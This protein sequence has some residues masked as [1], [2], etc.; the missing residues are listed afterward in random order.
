MNFIFT[1][2]LKRLAIAL[3]S[4]GV[5]AIVYGFITDSHKAWVSLLHSNFYF[6]AI[7]LAS[8]FFLSVQYVAEVGWSV[9]IKRI[10][11][12]IGMYLPW[13]CAFML[14]IFAIGNHSIYDW[15]HHYF[16]E[17]FIEGTTNPNPQYD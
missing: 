6:L 17:E 7:A 15:T 11:M 8:T 12:A 10:L 1:N 3:M 4:I 16:Y 14:L 2:K 13:A 5:I 9:M